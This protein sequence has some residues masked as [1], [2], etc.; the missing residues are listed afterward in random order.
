ML[1]YRVRLPGEGKTPLKGEAR[2]NTNK[3]SAHH[4]CACVFIPLILGN[5]LH[6]SAHTKWVHQRG[7]HRRR[8][9][10][11]ESGKLRHHSNKTVLRGTAA[12]GLRCTSFVE[13]KRWRSYIRKYHRMTT[14]V[15]TAAVVS[16]YSST[17]YD[18]CRK[19]KTREFAYWTRALM[20]QKRQA[21]SPQRSPQN[22]N[23]VYCTAV[24]RD[25]AD[26]STQQEKSRARPCC[27]TGIR[28]PVV[29]HVHNVLGFG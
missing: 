10:H 12:T 9:T 21:S 14:T 22:R 24:C 5:G 18:V 4:M 13:E 19:K 16:R 28:V 3:K 25:K 1:R 20:K 2:K 29:D 17:W 11:D 8:V 7:T 23:A 6:L 27:C 15:V 26:P